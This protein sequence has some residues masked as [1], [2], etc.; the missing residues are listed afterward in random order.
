M[1]EL[2]NVWTLLNLEGLLFGRQDGRYL[3]SS[4]CNIL[5]NFVLILSCEP[6]KWMRNHRP[7]ER[8]P[9]DQQ[10]WCFSRRGWSQECRWKTIGVCMYIRHWSI[11]ASQY[12]NIHLKYVS[13]FVNK[14]S[15]RNSVSNL[16]R[17]PKLSTSSSWTIIKPFAELL[18]SF[19][20]KNRSLSMNHI[21]Y[22]AMWLA[23]ATSDRTF[24]K[25]V[26]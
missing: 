3:T 20:I 11:A 19:L 26:S 9:H 14:R 24:S 7:P 23:V 16:W 5:Q 1:D 21:V 6:Y 12:D 10:G 18:N 8:L 25:R 15:E 17:A 2:V 4:H 13:W 22:S